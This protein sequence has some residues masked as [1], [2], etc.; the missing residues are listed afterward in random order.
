MT[1]VAKRTPFQIKTL[2]TLAAN[3]AF[4][5]QLGDGI[6]EKLAG[7]MKYVEFNDG[8]YIFRQGDD[9]THF[10]YILLQL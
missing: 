3:V 2:T 6:R 5:A 7:V 4:T 10:L 9:A 1:P 8:E